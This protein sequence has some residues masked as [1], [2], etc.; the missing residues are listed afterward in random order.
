[1]YLRCITGD[2]PRAW[3]DWL[4]WAEYYYITSYHSALKATP[5]EVVFGRPPPA[6]L[7]Y[8]AGSSS[9]ETVDALLR[10]RDAFLKDVRERLLQA[11]AY[12]KRQY[13]GRHRHL[14]FAVDD[15]VLLRILHRSAQS[16]VPGPR[17]KLSLRFAGPF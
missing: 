11:Q 7:S 4:P 16:V 3:L 12:A 14:E 1:M 9:T 6:L 2:R 15:W 10:D 8:T 5:F 17:G 13:D